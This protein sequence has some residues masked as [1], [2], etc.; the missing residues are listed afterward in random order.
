MLSSIT[1]AEHY[2]QRQGTALLS[3]H[4]IPTNL[5]NHPSLVFGLSNAFF[6]SSTA[7]V[8]LIFSTGNILSTASCR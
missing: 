3:R 6:A 4:I 5:D 2:W 8:L 1:F 7:N